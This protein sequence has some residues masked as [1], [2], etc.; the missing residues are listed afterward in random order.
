MVAHAF[1]IAL[2]SIPLCAALM[3]PRHADATAMACSEPGLIG[4][5]ANAPDGSLLAGTF[6]GRLYRSMDQGRCFLPFSELPKAM[7]IG[8][9]AVAPT[10]LSWL[11]AVGGGTFPTGI[12][13][14]AAPNL[15]RSGDGGGTW[16]DSVTGLPRGAFAYEVVQATDG[17]LVLSFGCGPTISTGSACYGGLAR[18]TDGGRS[19]LRTTPGS[20][21]GFFTLAAGAQGE[22]VASGRV[23][24]SSTLTLLRSRDDGYT[25]RPAGKL[26]TPYGSL[27][28]LFVSPWNSSVLLAGYFGEGLLVFRSTDGGSRW[29]PASI[30]RPRAPLDPVCGFAAT[31]RG[32]T[33]LFFSFGDAP[34]IYRSSN[35]GRTW[36]LAVA[37]LPKAAVAVHNNV[38]VL[39]TAA[40]GNV[41][42]ATVSKF[43]NGIRRVQMSAGTTV[44]YRS[45]DGGETWSS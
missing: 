26:P 7:P 19:W 3:V 16:T 24:G 10:H 17:S 8:Y 44:V 20:D 6:A 31:A 18:S 21:N 14:L 25:W 29:A 9:L 43:F 5:L 34:A 38:Y 40:N 1:G 32:R 45:Y 4:A 11:V 15:F 30:R 33:V 12:G 22:V 35:D 13:Q 28:T 39:Q 23:G 36:Q 2:L 37:G 27:M 42:Y 41:I